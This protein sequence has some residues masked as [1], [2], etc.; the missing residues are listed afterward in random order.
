MKIVVT[1]R[2]VLKDVKAICRK[3]TGITTI[4]KGKKVILIGE[5]TAIISLGS[6]FNFCGI[7]FTWRVTTNQ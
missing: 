7:N 3:L 1:R 2:K 5:P 4:S 6:R